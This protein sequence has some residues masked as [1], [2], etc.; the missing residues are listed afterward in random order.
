MCSANRAITLAQA[1]TSQASLSCQNLEKTIAT[2]VAEREDLQGQLERVSREREGEE[3]RRG[4]YGRK[5]ERHRDRVSYV[6]QDSTAFRE[7]AELQ[8]KKQQLE[9][10]SESL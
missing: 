4:E 7:L 9:D 3:K 6:E 5:M 10:K 2:L 1:R 8:A